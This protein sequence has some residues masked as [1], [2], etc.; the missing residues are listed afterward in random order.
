M[1][2]FLNNSIIVY[3]LEQLWRPQIKKQKPS[4]RQAQ[5]GVFKTQKYYW[6]KSFCL[7]L[8]LQISMYQQPNP[9]ITTKKHGF[10]MI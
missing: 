3:P 5:T 1:Q 7:A 2:A 8:R 4:G 6:G 10:C 9:L